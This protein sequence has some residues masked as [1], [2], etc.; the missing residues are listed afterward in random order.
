MGVVAGDNINDIGKSQIMKVLM[1]PAEK[2]NS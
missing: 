2:V 1:S